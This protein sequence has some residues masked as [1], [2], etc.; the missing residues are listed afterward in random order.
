MNKIGENNKLSNVNM[1]P[2]IWFAIYIGIGLAITFIVPFPLSFIVY[3]G[4]YLFLQMYRLKSI[5]N[6][7]YHSYGLNKANKGTNNKGSN[8]FFKS[9]SN[10]LFGD[11]KFSQYNS[12]PLQFICMNCGKEH[13]KRSCPICGS[14]TVRLG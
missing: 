10:S 3:I 9:I 2:I 4:I 8:K 13:S 6:K 7:N 5:Q 1:S 12:E 14:K 11:N